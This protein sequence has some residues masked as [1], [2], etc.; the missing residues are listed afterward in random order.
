MLYYREPGLSQDAALALVA[1]SGRSTCG[2]VRG[3][4]PDA[5]ACGDG[6]CEAGRETTCAMDCLPVTAP[7]AIR[8][9]SRPELTSCPGD[10]AFDSDDPGDART[11]VAYTCDPS[12]E[13]ELSC[14]DCWP[15]FSDEIACATAACGERSMPV[16][17]SRDAEPVLCVAACVADGKGAR[18]RGRDGRIELRRTSATDR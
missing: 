18:L 9:A 13:N 7:A 2:S 5:A 12:V 17:T 15:E 8:S 16:Q 1:G 14:T 11:T 10:C 4:L 3:Q 6:T